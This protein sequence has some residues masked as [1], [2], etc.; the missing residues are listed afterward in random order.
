VPDATRPRLLLLDGHSLA[1]RAF[2]ALPVENFSTSTGQS[3]NAV[4]GFTSMLIN[5]LRDE[6]PTHVAVAF[7]V[8]RQTFR[9]EEYVEYKAN[10][11]TSPAEFSGQVSLIKEVL[12]ALNIPF[13]EKPGFEA[14]DVIGTLAQ[15]HEGP[16]DVVTG[17]RDLFQL[18]RDDKPVRI[19]Y[20]AEKYR[21]VDE[22]VVQEKYG[23]P[24]RGYAEFAVLRGDPSDGLP[25]V[26]GIGAK[27]A[28]ALV[29]KF[30][31]VSAM[32]EALSAGVTD[33]FPAGCRTKLERASDYLAVAPR[34]VQVRDD[35]PVDLDDDRLPAEPHDPQRL[36]ELSD[37]WGLDGPLNRLLAALREVG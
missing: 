3:T 11:S 24:G 33:G 35:V 4:Y 22:A 7:D 15:R 28:A 10:R 30:G 17:D 6:Q 27:T 34:V 37:R 8:S 1:Y 20:S 2:F 29:T 25:G 19:I 36:V 12:N 31:T 26:A 14:D 9:S 21:P 18:V 23:I 16:V 5:V 32:L 13:L